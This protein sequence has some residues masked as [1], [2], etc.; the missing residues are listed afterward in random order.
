MNVVREERIRSSAWWALGTACC[1]APVAAS[2]WTPNR[3]DVFFPA[4]VAVAL[5]GALLGPI[6]ARQNSTAMNPALLAA[7]VYP[8]ALTTA[9]GIQSIQ[10]EGA[11]GFAILAAVAGAAVGGIAPALRHLA[12]RPGAALRRGS[13]AWA[14]VSVLAVPLLGLGLL[15]IPQV[16]SYRLPSCLR[17][18]LRSP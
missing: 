18:L 1:A 5:T 13:S 7:T 6:W 3:S 17:A 10:D 16:V 8:A 2:L 12:A 15:G 11:W 4:L 14:L 9:L